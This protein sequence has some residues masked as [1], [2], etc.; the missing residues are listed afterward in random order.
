MISKA[1]LIIQTKTSKFP[2]FKLSFN[3]IFQ[4][5]NPI[6]ILIKYISF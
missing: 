6:N 5:L 1:L 2:Q 4:F 3:K